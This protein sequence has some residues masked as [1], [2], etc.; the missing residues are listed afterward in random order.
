MIA[1]YNV[2]GVLPTAREVKPNYVTR[3]FSSDMSLRTVFELSDEWHEAVANHQSAHSTPFPKPWT[4]SAEV[5]GY[6]ITPIINT[7]ELYREGKRMRHCVGNYANET[8]WGE[9]YFYHVEKEGKPIATVQLLRDGTKAKLGQVRGPCNSIVDK[10]ITQILRKW[11]RQ[12]QEVPAFERPGI[13]E[14]DGPRLFQNV[15]DLDA[16]IPF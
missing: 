4:G 16:A 2:P 1:A 15:G 11:I 14:G 13:A 6:Q 10:K 5:D 8:I 7:A 9:W 3:R 12:I